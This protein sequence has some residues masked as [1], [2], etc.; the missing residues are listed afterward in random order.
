MFGTGLLKKFDLGNFLG[1][2]IAELPRTSKLITLSPS[3]TWT[4]G[5]V[6]GVEA[7]FLLF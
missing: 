6:P 2:I 7:F 5:G 4:L 1:P 3:A